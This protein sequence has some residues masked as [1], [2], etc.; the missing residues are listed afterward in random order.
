MSKFIERN[1]KPLSLIVLCS[2][3]GYFLGNLI[4]GMVVGIAIVASITLLVFYHEKNY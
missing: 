2:C 4:F 1:K 3:V